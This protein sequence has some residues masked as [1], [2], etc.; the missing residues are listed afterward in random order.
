MN[1]NNGI[2]KGALNLVYNDSSSR[3]L[4][5]LEK[6][7]SVT[8]H[9]RYLKTLT[10]VIFKVKSNMSLETLTEIFPHKEINHSL[11]NRAMLQGRSVKTAMY[12]S[13]TISSFG[14]KI[15]DI[16]PTE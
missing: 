2:N 1:F 10:Y 16:L 6:D 14:P 8:I 7:K 9:H 4:E 12:G 15:W 3:F 11:G 5:F 13:E